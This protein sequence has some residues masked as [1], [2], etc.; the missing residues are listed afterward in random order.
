MKFIRFKKNI[1]VKVKYIVILHADCNKNCDSNFEHSERKHPF[2]VVNKSN[3]M[4]D[5]ENLL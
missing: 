1:K 5:N 4:N 2:D 3:N